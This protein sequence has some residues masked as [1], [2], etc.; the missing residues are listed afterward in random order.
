MAGR[1][2]L[3]SFLKGVVFL[4][5]L[6]PCLY[7]LYYL[8]LYPDDYQF[9]GADPTETLTHAMGQ[10]GWYFLFITL[11]ITPL[12]K[13]FKLSKLAQYRRMMGLY[14][15]F[16]ICLHMLSYLIFM[17]QLDFSTLVEDIYKRPYM[18][19][20]F[21]AWIGLLV[22]AITSTKGWIKKLKQNWVKLHKLV[23]G[24]SVLALLHFAWIQ[25]SDW[26]EALFYALLTMLL[27][28][29]RV[30]FAVKAR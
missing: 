16:Y 28:G 12:R 18:T 3:N 5:A 25:R 26:S 22:L 1:L 4:V 20:G 9:W 11:S 8:F 2:R 19:V 24:I 27:L 6:T 13:L 21:V 10:W 23:Y 15:F 30:W 7:Y 14:S 29:V 17:L